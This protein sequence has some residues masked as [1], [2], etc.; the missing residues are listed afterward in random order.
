[1]SKKLI[2]LLL[3]LFGIGLAILL[4]CC[5]SVLL[6]VPIFS[7]KPIFDIFPVYPDGKPTP[8]VTPIDTEKNKKTDEL[9]SV[10]INQKYNPVLKD[11]YRSNIAGLSPLRLRVENPVPNK[12]V[13]LIYRPE[14]DLLI[15]LLE[16]T[17]AGKDFP[18]GESSKGNNVI[19]ET[20]F[21]EAEILEWK[22]KF[23]NDLTKVE[24]PKEL[25]NLFKSDLA[26]EDIK[27]IVFK[28]RS[29]FI[30]ILRI[31][32]VNPGL[33]TELDQNVFPAD[34]DHLWVSTTDNIYAEF[35][36]VSEEAYSKNDRKDM[37][38]AY[39]RFEMGAAFSYS[40]RIVD[41][42]L[43]GPVPAGQQAKQEYWM[44]ARE[45]GLRVVFF[46]EM[47]HVL[48][49]AYR[50]ELAKTMEEDKIYSYPKLQVSM[51]GFMPDR[52]LWPENIFEEADNF[53]VQMEAQGTLLAHHMVVNMFD[54]NQTQE[55]IL[56][57]YTGAGKRVSQVRLALVKIRELYKQNKLYLSEPYYF[58]RKA[59]EI[60]K[61][62]SNVEVKR[63]LERIEVNTDINSIS[64]YAGY[65]AEYDYEEISNVLGRLT[66]TP[67]IRE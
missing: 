48:Q 21:S 20:D 54:M 26:Q 60:S 2:T 16:L 27:K 34:E 18:G 31:Y 38:E 25:E 24:I 7:G 52:L 44:N 50:N 22:N 41:S 62:F 30:E 28:A 55:K 10:D 23:E 67:S 58:Q 49:I 51:E 17:Q 14:L 63:F 35:P 6:V 65:V 57:D 61:I 66:E 3:V 59:K 33:I 47:V 4:I 45:I 36:F 5:V 9:D 13:G 56:W 12:D 43:L 15:K 53:V 11:E 1:M 39:M 37:S 8:T 46:H 40:N 19:S 42:G 29:E 64:S 32:G